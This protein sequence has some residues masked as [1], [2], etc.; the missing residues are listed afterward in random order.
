MGVV[1]ND[2]IT[3]EANAEKLIARN[4]GSSLSDDR[5]GGAV[6]ILKNIDNAI[7]SKPPLVRIKFAN[8]IV[9]VDPNGLLGWISGLSWKPNLEM[10]MY[11]AGDQKNLFPKAI[12][13]S[14]SF[15]VLHEQVLDQ[16]SIG[17][18]PFGG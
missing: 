16:K 4:P 6:D 3:V 14:F 5:S 2:P 1:S 10:G 18:F 13:L 17:A 12:A 15:N 7:L 9:G 11:T 8:L